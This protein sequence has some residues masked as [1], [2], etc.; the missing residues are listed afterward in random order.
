[1]MLYTA[2]KKKNY[3]A[4]SLEFALKKVI[5]ALPKYIKAYTELVQLLLA[6]NR[7][8]EAKEYLAKVQILTSI[9]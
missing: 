2:M 6:A 3:D 9:R 4:G 5:A 8:S 1:M 7:K